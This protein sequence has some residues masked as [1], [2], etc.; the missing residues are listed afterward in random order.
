[1]VSITK[2]DRSTQVLLVASGSDTYHSD[3]TFMLNRLDV[4]MIHCRDIY[5]A[6]EEVLA[7]ADQSRLV[8]VGRY[9]ALQRENRQFFALCANRPGT[10]CCCLLDTP[11]KYKPFSDFYGLVKAG[12]KFANTTGELVL[13]TEKQLRKIQKKTSKKGKS[14]IEDVPGNGSSLRH[15][16]GALTADELQALLGETLNAG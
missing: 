14:A 4:P 6:A 10:V 8:V 9:A 13:L 12:I 7:C 5:H 16:E 2:S 1:M 3:L 15:E 11:E